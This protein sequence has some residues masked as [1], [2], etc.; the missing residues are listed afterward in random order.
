MSILSGVNPVICCVPVSPLRA[1]PWHRSEMVSQLLFG[2]ACDIIEP[3]NREWCRIR[4]RYDGYEG[5]CQPAHLVE[6]TAGQGGDGLVG[7]GG[8][9][10]TA[11]WVSAV[12]YDGRPMMVP[13]GSELT[14]VESGRAFWGD[15][16]IEFSG[17]GWDPATA[18]REAAAIAR[19]AH[20]FLNTPY[21]WGGKSVFGIDC[22]GFAQTVFKFL[23]VPLLRDACLQAG[24]GEAVGF[25]EETR[26]GDLAFFDNDEGRITHVGILLGP[27]E[28]IHSSGK[29]RVD[30]IDNMGIVNADSGVRTHRL[31]LIKRL[32]AG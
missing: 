14:G 13:L 21:L 26:T 9:K 28:I 31:R 4:A 8:A 2:E 12:G 1:E 10:L 22:S 19:L 7:G 30:P 5:C 25:L 27:G 18:T 23:G 11:D 24:Q 6:L 15:H 16:R 3:I 17:A 29:V 32:L 20:R